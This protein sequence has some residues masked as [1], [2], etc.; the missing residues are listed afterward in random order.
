MR[1]KALAWAPAFGIVISCSPVP[2]EVTVAKADE[3]AAAIRSA[4]PYYDQRSTV[5][6]D[7]AHEGAALKGDYQ[8]GD[9]RR[10]VVDY[11]HATSRIVETYYFQDALFLMERVQFLYNGYMTGV[12][13]DTLWS[14][15][16]L[17]DGEVVWV[18]GDVLQ[19]QWISSGDTVVAKARDLEA[20]LPP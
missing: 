5:D 16:Y 3:S 7:L 13:Q 20:R 14:K 4:A 15:V 8:D 9:L 12:Y 19:A 11:L 10:L 1:I 18:E 6:L 17:R 2:P